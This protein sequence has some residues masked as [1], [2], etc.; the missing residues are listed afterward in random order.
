[1]SVQW[2]KNKWMNEIQID[3]KALI[4]ETA[5]LNIRKATKICQIL[6]SPKKTR[7][8]LSGKS[9]LL[10]NSLCGSICVCEHKDVHFGVLCHWIECHQSKF[11]APFHNERKLVVLKLTGVERKVSYHLFLW[12]KI[13]QNNSRLYFHGHC[14]M[15]VEHHPWEENLPPC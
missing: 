13:S 12:L 11:K 10:G 9:E 3:F 1:M 2:L 5:M 7:N 15:L 8:I 14:L 6:Y 4:L